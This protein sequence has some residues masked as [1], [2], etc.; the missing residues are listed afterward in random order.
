[1]LTIYAPSNNPKS[2]AWEVFSGIQQSWP[3]QVC[4]NDNAMAIEPL[5]NSMFWGFVGNNREMVKK[6]ES[7]KKNYSK[8]KKL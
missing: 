8:N 5:S 6:L 3:E 7:R 4:V 2:K 1:M